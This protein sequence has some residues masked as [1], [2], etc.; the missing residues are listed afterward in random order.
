MRGMR[1]IEWP[2]DWQDEARAALAPYLG[3]DQRVRV[4]VGPPTSRHGS[5]MEGFFYLDGRTPTCLF[6]RSGR[7]DVFPWTVLRGPVLRIEEL[8]P[9]RPPVEVYTHPQWGVR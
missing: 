3:T 1:K 2:Q 4:T 6:D 7:A 5:V 9:R 8:R